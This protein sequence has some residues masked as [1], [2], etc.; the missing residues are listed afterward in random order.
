[1]NPIQSLTHQTDL[2]V[3]RFRSIIEDRGPYLVIKTPHNPSFHWGNYLLFPE[4]PQSHDRNRWPDLFR[5]E[6]P[7][8]QTVRHIAF[9]WDA[10]ET[11]SAAEFLSDGYRLETTVALS[12]HQPVLPK[13]ANSDVT[14]RTFTSD[15]EF[16]A[17]L[18]IQVE[19]REPVFSEPS[20][21]EF[22]QRQM[23]LYRQMIAQ[24]YG[25]WFGAFLGDQL[26]GDLGVFHA[27]GVA[28]YQSVSTHPDHRCQGICGRL[29][30]AAGQHAL[31]QFPNVHTLV[32]VAEA[33]HQAARVYQSAGFHPRETTHALSCF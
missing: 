3:S 18:E 33:N 16:A 21:R 30:Y 12:T 7:D 31:Q 4:P 26:V 14:I 17:A 1:M 32:M 6:F 19:C 9:T 8:A 5:R 24:G 15:E 25:Q 13:R 20:Y 28:R 23:D 27:D 22:C 29:V 10:P 2:L 11:G